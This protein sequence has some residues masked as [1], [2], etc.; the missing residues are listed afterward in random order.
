MKRRS[1]KTG[2]AALSAAEKRNEVVKYR[3]AGLSLRKI[4]ERLGCSEA[5]CR[6]HLKRALA[7]LNDKAAEDYKEMR[8][9]QSERLDDMLTGVY[10]AAAK[11]NPGAVAAALR[12]MERQASLWGLDAPKQAKVDLDATVAIDAQIESRNLNANLQLIDATTLSED[13]Q[14]ALQEALETIGRLTARS[15][16]QAAIG[17]GG[18]LGLVAGDVSADPEDGG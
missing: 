4:G 6:N 5:T 8:R 14:R 3:K 15:A 7:I 12:I 11:G 2:F 16:A 13:E 18:V 9:L 1:Q 10:V 17:Q